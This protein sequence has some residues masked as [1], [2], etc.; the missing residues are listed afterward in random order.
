MKFGEG[1]LYI[2][3][4]LIGSGKSSLLSSIL[5]DITIID[6]QIKINGTLSYAAQDAWIFGDTIRQNILFGEK[7]DVERYERTVEVCSLLED[8][9]QLPHSD[10][11]IVGEKGISLSGG[12]KA[13]INLARAIYRRADIYLLDD[14]LSAVS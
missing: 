14:P 7:F 9:R 13:R 6:G 12:Q 4:G 8:F 3:V 2:V 10:L 1:K 5:G 11:S